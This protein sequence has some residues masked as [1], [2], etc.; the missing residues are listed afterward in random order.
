MTTWW[1]T[2][3][4]K[5]REPFPPDLIEQIPKGGTRLD[6]V[7]H[8][9]VTDRLI[10]VDPEWTWQPLAYDESGLPKL[11][12]VNGNVELWILLTVGG[13]SM[14]GVG[15]AQKTKQELSKELIGDALR[16]AAMRMGVALD[17]WSKSDLDA[18]PAVE[19]VSVVSDTPPSGR[20]RENASDTK[21][22]VSA[23]VLAG[24][25]MVLEL[26]GGDAEL[27]SGVW[28]MAL[29]MTGAGDPPTVTQVDK[30]VKYAKDNLQ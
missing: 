14:V 7:G 15:T 24:K 4:S 23:H 10:H 8:A 25:N 20:G 6:Y 30:A 1:D 18:S 22:R 26:C 13:R 21:R 19:P 3:G 16:N 17:L 2:Y 27:A 9:A 29:E 12:E 5:L 28:A 11:R